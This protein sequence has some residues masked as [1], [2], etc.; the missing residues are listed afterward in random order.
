[1]K[2]LLSTSV[3]LGL[4]AIPPVFSAEEISSVSEQVIP[5][6]VNIN[7]A[8]ADELVLLKGIGQSKALAIIEYRNA[9]GQFTSI[10]ELSQVKGIGEK[11]LEQNRTM[12]TL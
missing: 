8:T 5:V 7:T 4:L 6:Q 1:M 9:H 10:E 2:M 11:L 3:L 12:L